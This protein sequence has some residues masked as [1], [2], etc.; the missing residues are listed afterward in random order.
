ME[1][2]HSL[3]SLLG[4]D[5]KNK[6]NKYVQSMSSRLLI[7]LIYVPNP[8][9]CVC[10]PLPVCDDELRQSEQMHDVAGRN[11]PG[12]E[13]YFTICPGTWNSQTGAKLTCPAVGRECD[14][15]RT[16]N[17]TPDKLSNTYVVELNP[18]VFD[19]PYALIKPQPCT[20]GTHDNV[21]YQTLFSER[22]IGKTSPSHH[23]TCSVKRSHAT[24]ASGRNGSKHFDFELQPVESNTLLLCRHTPTDELSPCRTCDRQILQ[25]F[26]C[27]KPLTGRA[28]PTE[29]EELE[30]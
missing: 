17:S 26:A 27:N 22:L 16:L 15:Y 21:H 24:E 12:T 28:P 25:T 13:P 6:L 11:T 30:C 20:S 2:L 7:D 23:N 3:L 18:N 14:P 9:A 8:A 19:Q 1:K 10:F 4:I 29:T 5:R